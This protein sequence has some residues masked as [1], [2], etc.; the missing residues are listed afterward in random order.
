MTYRLKALPVDVY[1]WNGVAD[2]PTVLPDWAGPLFMGAVGAFLIVRLPSERQAVLA[3]GW[4]LVRYP[5]G[6]VVVMA[7]EELAARVEEAAAP[8]PIQTPTSTLPPQP[9]EPVT[10]EVI[11]GVDY[12]VYYASGDQY[13]RVRLKMPTT[14]W[15]ALNPTTTTGLP[16]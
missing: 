6:D 7:P 15:N 13:A 5:D 3:K 12:V 16:K 4:G 10:H 11:N 9:Y 2:V 14:D 8:I 1:E